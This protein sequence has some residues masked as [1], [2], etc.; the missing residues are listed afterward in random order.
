MSSLVSSIQVLAR[1]THFTIVQVRHLNLLEYQSK[2][3]LRKNG[4][5]VQDFCMV[6]VHGTNELDKF[7]R[8]VKHWKKLECG[9]SKEDIC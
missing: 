9:G 6:D 2:H 1:R 4:V 5:A 3:L 8:T 7:M